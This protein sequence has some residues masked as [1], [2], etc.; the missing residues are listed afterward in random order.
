MKSRRS[1]LLLCAHFC[2]LGLA[3]RAQDNTALRKG[4]D[5]IQ[6]GHFAEAERWLMEAV[7]TDPRSAQAQMELA[8]ARL[9]LGNPHEAV[10]ALQQAVILAPAMPG[11]HMFLGIGYV[12]MNRLDD[13]VGALEQEI[14]L[15]P[16]D[17]QAQMWLGAVQL[18]AGRA[19]MATA[20]LDRAA[21]LTPDDVD[22]LEYRGKAHEAVA[23]ASYARIAH[24]DSDSWHVHKLQGELHAAQNQHVE[25]IAEY[26]EAIRKKPDN[27]DLYEA[28]GNEYR[29]LAQLDKAQQAYQKELELSPNNPIAMY[30]LATIDIEREQPEKGVPLLRQV[31]S[32]YVGASAAYFYLG[33]GQSQMGDVAG[34]VAALRKA[35][36]LHPEPQLTMQVE[37]QLAHNYR[38]LGDS[39]AART[40]M[41]AYAKLKA[42]NAPQ[43]GGA[44]K[45]TEAAA[46]ER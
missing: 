22:V 18:K 11:A 31:I 30:N 21:E 3:A 1:L 19:E 32:S 41:D 14:V 16:S 37:Y 12:Q 13:A 29:K 4:S 45:E 8:I 39:A 26:L 23:Q 5:A 2:L 9:R 36:D 38:K 10:A 35:L 33:L 15:N 44:E 25:A 42:K 28:L 7:R 34:A 6:T 46:P 27:A 20:P 40:A 17:A 24:L 43:T